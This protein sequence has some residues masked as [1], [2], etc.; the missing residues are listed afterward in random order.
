LE[1][2]EEAEAEGEDEDE[3][4]LSM[5]PEE[6]SEEVLLLCESSL[7][8]PASRAPF[9]FDSDVERPSDL[10]PIALP[11]PLPPPLLAS[12][13]IPQSVTVCV[14]GGACR[15]VG[16]VVRGSQCDQYLH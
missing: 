2:G 6:V 13:P 14:C 15:V 4:F 11:L 10:P 1:D 7:P 12:V 5:L 9:K 16:R 3:A 8:R